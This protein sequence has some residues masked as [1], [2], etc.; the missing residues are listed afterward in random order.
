MILSTQERILL[1]LNKFF[2]DLVEHKLSEKHG[3]KWFEQYLVPYVIAYTQDRSNKNNKNFEKYNAF[4]N[5]NNGNY[6]KKDIDVTFASALL[7]YDDQI[8]LEFEGNEKNALNQLRI[9]RNNYGHATDLTALH[10]ISLNSKTLIDLKN[11]I[12]TFGK[13]SISPGMFEEIEELEQAVLNPTAETN[14]HTRE[15]IEE[16]ICDQEYNRAEDLLKKGNL[17]EAYAIHIEL[18]SQGHTPSTIRLGDFYRLGI[19]VSSDIDRSVDLYEKAKEQGEL[20]V[21]EVI[22][23]LKELKQNSKEAEEGKLN[24]QFKLGIVYEEG[25]LVPQD[26]EKAL[27]WYQKALSQKS[28]LARNRVV[29]LAESGYKNAQYVVAE[30][31]ELGRGVEKDLDKALVEYEKI[32][33]GDTEEIAALEKVIALTERDAESQYNLGIYYHDKKNYKEAYKHIKRSAENGYANAMNA[34]GYL[35]GY[36]QGVEKNLETSFKWTEKAAEQGLVKAQRNVGLLYKN[37]TGVEKNL[38]ASFNWYKRAA[39]HGDGKSERILG[40]FYKRG[41]GVKRDYHMAFEY[42]QKAANKGE[43]VAQYELGLCY[44]FGQGT[45]TNHTEEVKWYKKAASQNNSDAQHNL[46]VCYCYGDGVDKDY[47]MAYKWFFKAAKAKNPRALYSLG[48]C[49]EYGYGT[50]VNKEEAFK[51]YKK[52]ADLGW[53]RA[54]EKV[55]PTGGS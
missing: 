9:A 38:K 11:A 28:L 1:L 53:K 50:Y 41:Y 49:Y 25:K 29:S 35:Y 13:E 12:L 8:E 16:S 51:C 20:S 10:R 33:Y 18:D 27:Y 31:Y 43:A 26:K 42:F 30:A 40:Q 55:Y 17:E 15:K 21:S 52:S 14:G 7:L 32:L 22:E 5:K 19:Y 54:I 23:S 46:G 39:E 37:G 6:S 4:L 48:N 47:S 2:Q 24:S 34:L 36:G 45:K 44:G 3:E